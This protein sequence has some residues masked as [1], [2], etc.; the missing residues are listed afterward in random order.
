MSTSSSAAVTLASVAVL[1]SRLAVALLLGWAA[2]LVTLLVAQ[3][4]DAG[5][6][7]MH[8]SWQASGTLIGG[9][10]AWA[11]WLCGVAALGSP[12][13]L[14]LA[15]AIATLPLSLAA[16]GMVLQSV[17]SSRRS[18]RFVWAGAAGVTLLAAVAVSSQ[19]MGWRVPAV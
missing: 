16:T 6:P 7:R 2:S 4:A 17:F 11:G 13:G 12:T 5:D 18:R 3:R 1:S 8:R 15:G 9:I 19:A 10:C 14:P